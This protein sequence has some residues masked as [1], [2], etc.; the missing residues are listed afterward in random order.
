[1]SIWV[2]HRRWDIGATKSRKA[3]DH[4]KI[5]GCFRWNPYLPI[6][7]W[8]K[9][10]RAILFWVYLFIVGREWCTNWW[11]GSPPHCPPPEL[12]AE[13]Q[14]SVSRS[15]GSCSRGRPTGRGIAI[16]APVDSRCSKRLSRDTC[17]IDASSYRA[18]KNFR[19]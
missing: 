11:P 15:K 16:K 19:T 17:S 18:K 2:E 8:G 5:K 1:M 9:T 14:R 4:P 6:L 3:A 10:N 12:C 13:P 7:D